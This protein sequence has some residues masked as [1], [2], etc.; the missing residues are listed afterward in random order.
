MAACAVYEAQTRVGCLTP[1]KARRKAR[2]IVQTSRRALP[3]LIVSVSS[4]SA[5]P[6]LTALLTSSETSKASE[7][8]SR[9]WQAKVLN[10]VLDVA[11]SGGSLQQSNEFVQSRFGGDAVCL[12]IACCLLREQIMEGCQ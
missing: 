11:F 8:P 2:A 1:V 3:S 12:H 10:L 5:R 7:A 9:H 4:I 6:C